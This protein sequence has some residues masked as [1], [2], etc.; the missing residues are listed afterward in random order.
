[1]SAG[2]STSGANTGGTTLVTSAISTTSGRTIDIVVVWSSGSTFTS[3]TDSAGNTWTQIGSEVSFSSAIARRYRAENITGSASHTFTLTLGSAT[4]KSMFVVEVA[5]ATASS[6]DQQASQLDASSPFTSGLTATTAQANEDIVEACLGTSSSATD[7]TTFTN[8]GVTELQ[9]I[10]DASQ[11]W[12]GA[13]GLRS[14]TATGTYSADATMAAS[15]SAY[16]WVA[17]YRTGDPPSYR[18]AWLTA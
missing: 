11:F 17:T 2:V 13:V 10:Q 9:E 3:I 7:T 16:M 1:M 18:I 5:G 8:S 4:L 6:F 14:V 15:T 12:N